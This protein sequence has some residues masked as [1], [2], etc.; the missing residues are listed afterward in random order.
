MTGSC[1]Y[2]AA[3]TA[4]NA[5][6]TTRT[7]SSLDRPRGTDVYFGWGIHICLGQWL[8]RREAQLVFEYVAEKLPNYAVGA[9]ERVLTATVR[10]YTSVEMTLR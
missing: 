4:T 8:A 3:P 7:G 6:T 10:G 5:A 2:L 9:S 1:C